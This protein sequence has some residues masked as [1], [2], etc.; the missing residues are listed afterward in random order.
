MSPVEDARAL[1]SERFPDAVWAILAGSVLTA[2]RTAG[3]DLDIVV[4]TADGNYR[5]TVRYRGWPVELFVQ[6]EASLDRFFASEDEARKPSLRR[7][8]AT[9]VVV[10]GDPGPLPSAC[11]SI[12]A[13]GPRPLT[14]GEID[15]LRYAVT[16][17]IDDLTHVVDP[18]ERITLT[19]T[20]WV[21]AGDAALRLGGSWV[22]RGKW[23]LREMRAMDPDLA[24][25]W[26]A[27][28][29]HPARVVDFARRVLEPVGGILYDGYRSQ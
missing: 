28:A 15:W 26:L 21:A 29:G 20:G 4:F 11:A 22:G 2:D 12:L 23:L 19:G 16:D 10:A 14:L 24:D 18:G 13:A 5:E 6:N 17:L 25:A 7:M 1:V 27:A 3:S 8:I 9:G